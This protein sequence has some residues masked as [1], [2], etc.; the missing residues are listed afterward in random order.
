MRLL[1]ADE[2]VLALFEEDP[3]KGAVPRWARILKVKHRFRTLQD[4]LMDFRKS[5]T[6]IFWEEVSSEIFIP[7]CG[8]P[9]NLWPEVLPKDFHSENI[10][11]KSQALKNS[12][13]VKKAIR[14]KKTT[15]LKH[16]RFLKKQQSCCI[17]DLTQLE[18]KIE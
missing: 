11:W 13:R 7:E 5:N 10:Y 15:S 1:Q 16:P 18:S 2:D 14:L 12:T 4:V 17:K 6:L 3:H 8:F 9:E